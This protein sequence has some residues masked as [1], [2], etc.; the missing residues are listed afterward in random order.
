LARIRSVKPELRTSLTAAE[1]SREVRYFWVLLWGYLD[2]H[3]RGVDEPRLIKADCFPLDD[4]LT[5]ADIDK[6]LEM[7]ATPRDDEPA[8][9]CRYAI[10][11]R[12][13]LHIPRWTSHQKP[14]HP[15]DS[16]IPGCP[17]GGDCGRGSRTSH[18]PLMNPR[19]GFPGA[20]PAAGRTVP[21]GEQAA[22]EPPGAGIEANSDITAAQSQFMSGSRNAHESLSGNGISNTP[23]PTSVRRE[24]DGEVD[25][26]VE[27][28]TRK[29]P[30]KP[31][32][33]DAE[34][35]CVHLA[36][37][38]EGNGS[39]RPAITQKWRDAARLMLDRDGRTEQQV[40][41]A[42]DW[43]QGSEFW[44]TNILSMPTLREQYDRLRLQAQRDH[45]RDSPAAAPG[46]AR[47]A[48]ALQ[49]GIAAGELMR[50]GAAS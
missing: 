11:G 14:Q 26:T 48:E 25:G 8:S 33:E 30:A 15:T 39:K 4:D 35:L 42:I 22:Q 19:E 50:R 41:A 20:S 17:R 2:D 44:R 36:D 7:L 23:S 38:I 24:G 43:C 49:A 1:W 16:K 46:T 10:G 5:A 37:R 47:A 27:G 31:H 18:E 45:G 9:V 34:R 13:Y 3:G 29:A 12:R 21:G 32:R 6:W 28:E 40:H